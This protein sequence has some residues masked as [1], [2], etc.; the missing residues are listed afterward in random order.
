MTW[1][2]EMMVMALILICIV[3]CLYVKYLA[4][5]NV[6]LANTLEDLMDEQK[7]ILAKQKIFEKRFQ[8]MS[9]PVDKI[10]IIHK[11]DDPNHDLKFGD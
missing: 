6:D 4:N 2:L 7:R 5:E 11:W 1:V 8:Q 9:E 10:E 3:T